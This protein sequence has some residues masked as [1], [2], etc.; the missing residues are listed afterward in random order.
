MIY[1]GITI[2]PTVDSDKD[3]HGTHTAGIIAA[4]EIMV[5]EYQVSFQMLD[6]AY[7]NIHPNYIGDYAVAD[8]IVWAVDN[9]AD[10]LSNSWG[11]GGYSNILKMHLI[12][13]LRTT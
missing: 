4:K 7:K 3:G 1:Q 10:V 11:G 5:K 8:G 13:L 2:D 12:T 6:Y 9:G